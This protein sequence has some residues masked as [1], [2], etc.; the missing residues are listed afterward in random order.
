VI[1]SRRITDFL[2]SSQLGVMATLGSNGPQAAVVGVYFQEGAGELIIGTSNKSRKFQNIKSNA[3]VAV[4]QVAGSVTVQLEGIAE[5]LGPNTEDFKKYQS[6]VEA[7]APF[8][9]KFRDDP[10][11]VWIR[12]KPDWIR[13]TDISKHPWDIEEE[14]IN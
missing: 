13:L 3:R 12:V 9:K 14:K 5:V 6:H 10:T 8:T 7:V 2:K 11:Q 1:N 4:A